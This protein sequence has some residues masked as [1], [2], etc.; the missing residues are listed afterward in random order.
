[1]AAIAATGIPYIHDNKVQV[2]QT[3]CKMTGGGDTSDGTGVLQH[4]V[5]RAQ[6]ALS[7]SRAGSQP[8]SL[9]EV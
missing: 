8:K 5:Q 4:A 6:E 2:S 7:L 3:V 9:S 1:M